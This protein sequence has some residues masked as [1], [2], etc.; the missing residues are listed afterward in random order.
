[1]VVVTGIKSNVTTFDRGSNRSVSQ[2]ATARGIRLSTQEAGAIGLLMFGSANHSHYGQDELLDYYNRLPMFSE[3]ANIMRKGSTNP[4]LR[5]SACFAAGYCSVMLGDITPERLGIF[6]KVA[7]SGLPEEEIVCNAPLVLRK[8]FLSGIK[9]KDG[10]I[11]GQGSGARK[12]QFEIT[13]QAICDFEK[14]SKRVKLYIP[15]DSMDKII[16][17]TREKTTPLLINMV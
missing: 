12:A 14:E 11:I 4:I 1:M 8:A 7:N 13:Y 16:G 3:T 5:K 2:I 15:D 6:S 9:G 17:M 10:S